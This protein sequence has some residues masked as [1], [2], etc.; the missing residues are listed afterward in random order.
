MS[1]AYTKVY[2]HLRSAPQAADRWEESPPEKQS[3]TDIDFEPG[4]PRH[5]HFSVHNDYWPHTGELI[6]ID[7]PL[8]ADTCLLISATINLGS[9]PTRLAAQI[10][11][12]TASLWQATP[13]H[14]N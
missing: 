7:D 12:G 3:V 8:I 11:P 14:R 2:R 13:P 1:N 6:Q 4:T 9:A 10:L 5:V